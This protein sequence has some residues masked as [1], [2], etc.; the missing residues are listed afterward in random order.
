MAPEAG[1]Q[2]LLLYNMNTYGDRMNNNET[3]MYDKEKN[4]NDSK[5]RKKKQ[6]DTKNVID[7]LYL[8]YN[9]NYNAIIMQL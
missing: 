1:L 3:K 8:R 2:N 4:K 5:T 6:I 9:C 7:A